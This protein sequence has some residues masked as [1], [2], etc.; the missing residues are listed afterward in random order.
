MKKVDILTKMKNAGIIAVIR[1]K[2]FENAIKTVDAVIAGGITGIELTF[3]VPQAD[4]VIAKLTEK[5]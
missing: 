5:Y 4:Q 3:T 1:S 2:N